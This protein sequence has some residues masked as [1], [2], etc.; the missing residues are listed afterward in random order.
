MCTPLPLLTNPWD[1]T[2]TLE[3][4]SACSL[5]LMGGEGWLSLE[6]C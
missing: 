5:V 3:S 1:L 6:Q 2:V 4:F